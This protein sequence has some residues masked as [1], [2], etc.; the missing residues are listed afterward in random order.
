MRAQDYRDMIYASLSMRHLRLPHAALEYAVM[1][2]S[3]GWLSP[4][5]CIE[6]MVDVIEQAGSPE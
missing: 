6:M 4:G 1:E 2:C 3:S 5:A